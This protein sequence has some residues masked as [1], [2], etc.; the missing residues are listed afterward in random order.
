MTSYLEISNCQDALSWLHLRHML[1]PSDE[2]ASLEDELTP[3]HDEPTSE[4]NEAEP[5][6]TEA[7]RALFSI[8]PDCDYD[9]YLLSMMAWKA[10]G[11]DLTTF[12]DWA[13]ASSEKYPGHEELSKK[14]NGLTGTGIT[15]ATLFVFAKRYGFQFSRSDIYP[16]L[17]PDAYYGIAGEV[18]RAVAQISEADPAAVLADFLARACAYIGR[19]PYT[20]VGDTEHHCR[21]YTAIVG[22]T[23]RARKG[24]ASSAN[25]R[26]FKAV[27]SALGKTGP[28][29]ATGP[30]ES[31][32]GLA[33]YVRD[34]SADDPG[35]EDKRLLLNNSEL[36][37]DI[38]C[39]QRTGNTLSQII[40]LLWDGEDVE[41][42]TKHDRVRATGAHVCISGS[43]TIAELLSS[44]ST[45]N[46]KN[47]FANRFLFF[48]VTRRKLV[49]DPQPLEDG[50]VVK[51][52]KQIADALI[53][54][55][56]GQISFDDKAR[57][58]WKASYPKLTFDYE[59][60]IG[61]ITA[62]AE[63]QTRRLSL[64]YAVL[65]GSKTI[66]EE[67]VKAALAVWEYCRKSVEFIF[68][69]KQ[70]SPQ[71]KISDDKEKL[72]EWMTR[73][74]RDRRLITKAEICKGL[75]CFRSNAD[76]AAKVLG[77]LVGEK[78]LEMHM[79]DGQRMGY[80]VVD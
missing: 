55:S 2:L 9:T 11:Y 22:K 25:K 43:I 20:M 75:T 29:T 54:V 37:G 6:R 71:Q 62:R 66:K 18:V 78:R 50:V 1:L 7:K 74:G 64:L 13:K 30:V 59:G 48:V 77:Q 53:K 69:A 19:A 49:D 12:D 28:R 8:P 5:L 65:D 44:L 79:T 40:R 27:E 3:F 51:L 15:V 73:N 26:L 21:L 72:V 4:G 70:Q 33:Y 58:L 67:H 32:E 68:G 23:A 10:G 35:V 61:A 57:A 14:W 56:D 42:L 60:I 52:S 31:G 45:S 76:Y 39:M 38:T 46:K 63:A 47:G 17:A 36:A 24:T 16:K 80:R 41:P 34:Q